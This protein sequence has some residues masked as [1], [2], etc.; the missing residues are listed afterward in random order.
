MTR[1]SGRTMQSHFPSGE[2][3]TSL[4]PPERLPGTVTLDILRPSLPSS[5][6][7]GLRWK[8]LMSVAVDAA[9]TLPSALRAAEVMLASPLIK[10]LATNS[11]LLAAASS[12]SVVIFDCLFKRQIWTS[13]SQKLIIS[14]LL[15]AL[16]IGLSWHMKGNDLWFSIPNCRRGMT[17][18]E[19]SGPAA[20]SIERSQEEELKI[21]PDTTMLTALCSKLAMAFTSCV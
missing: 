16:R 17:V 10:I 13:R 7:R 21:P 3:W 11:L 5:N 8:S 6:L 12:F 9:R 14:L 19:A 2:N 1:E 4:A 15:G 20:V 18:G